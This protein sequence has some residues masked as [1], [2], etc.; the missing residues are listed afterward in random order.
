MEELNINIRLRKIL[1]DSDN[2]YDMPFKTPSDLMEIFENL[3]EKNR[4]C[5]LGTL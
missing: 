3:E 4:A 2:E 1:E 5:C